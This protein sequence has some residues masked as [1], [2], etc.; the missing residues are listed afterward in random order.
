MT[1]QR[2]VRGYWLVALWVTGW[3]AAA[4]DPWLLLPLYVGWLIASPHI[5]P[6]AVSRLTEEKSR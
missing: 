1:Y 2:P 6:R 4:T 3:G 5:P